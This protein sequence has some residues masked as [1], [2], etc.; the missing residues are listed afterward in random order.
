[1]SEAARV[2]SL[3]DVLCGAMESSGDFHVAQRLQ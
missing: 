2:L 1:M 3:V